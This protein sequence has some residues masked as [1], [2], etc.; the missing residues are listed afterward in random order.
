MKNNNIDLILISQSEI[1]KYSKYSKFPIERISIYKNLIYPR[2]LYY[3]NAFR[4]HLD[5]LNKLRFGIFWDEASFVD[6]RTLFSIWNLPGFVGTHLANYLTQFGIKVCV[7]NNFDAEWDLFCDAYE[8]SDTKPLVG[9]S[10]TFHLDYSE[11]NRIISLIKKNYPKSKILLGGAFVNEQAD[12]IGTEGL[13]QYMNKYEIDF[14]VHSFNSEHDI[15]T[16]LTNKNNLRLVNNTILSR[17]LN[18]QRKNIITKTKWNDPIIENLPPHWKSLNMPFLNKTIQMRTSSGCPFSCAFC[19]Y[20]TLSKGFHTCKTE[21]FEVQLN[22]IT[23]QTNIKNIIFIDDTLNVPVTRFKSLCKIFAKK[24]FEWFSFLRVQFVTDEIAK[25]MKESGCRGVYLGIE[26]ANDQVLKN[27]NKKATKKQFKRGI[28]FLKKYDITSMAAFVLGFP[29]ETRET[30]NENIQ[31]IEEMRFDF[32]T[33]KEFYYL[34]NSPIYKNRHKFQLQG[35]ANKWSH[36]TMNSNS[37]Y[38]YKILMLRTIKNSVFI[39]PDISLWYIAYLYDQ[40]FSICEIKDIQRNINTLMLSQI[41]NRFDDMH[42]AY[43]KISEIL[44]KNMNNL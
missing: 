29:G 26:S 7:I 15:K 14:I 40:G 16:L 23:E 28:E 19:S 32:Y 5:V 3:K 10:T 43:D 8:N 12:T 22:G 36:K 33:V 21:F 25:L 37:V 4:S 35:D 30:I 44:K 24:D 27:M 41:D 9:I 34:K 17:P 11:I 1:V 6:R 31:F 42:P 18:E 20:P 2:M 38:D 39:D 13:I